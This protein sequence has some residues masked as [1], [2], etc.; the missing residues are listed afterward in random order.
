MRIIRVRALAR[1]LPATPEQITEL[2][3][4][5]ASPELSSKFLGLDAKT[6]SWMDLAKEL[7]ARQGHR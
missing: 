7:A 6:Y 4:I 2:Q 3:A 1:F 5:S